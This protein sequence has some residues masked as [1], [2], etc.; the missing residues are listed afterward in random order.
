M[1]FHMTRKQ[2]WLLLLLGH[3]TV[4]EHSFGNQRQYRWC[5]SFPAVLRISHSTILHVI[6]LLFT[7][8]S[9]VYEACLE[10][11][12]YIWKIL[13]WGMESGDPQVGIKGYKYSADFICTMGLVFSIFQHTVQINVSGS[14]QQLLK[15]EYQL[16]TESLSWAKRNKFITSDDRIS[17]FS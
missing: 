2:I 3:E 5:P 7:E 12:N 11:G 10:E 14:F 13:P 6:S 17:S 4:F 9:R 15:M 8:A 1:L 16:S